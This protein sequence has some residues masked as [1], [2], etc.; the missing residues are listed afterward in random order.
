MDFVQ[1]NADRYVYSPSL[2]ALLKICKEKTREVELVSVKASV[3]AR[4]HR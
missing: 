4:K 2:S 1:S 3:A